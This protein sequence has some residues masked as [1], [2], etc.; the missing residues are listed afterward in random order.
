MINFRTAHDIG[1]L[2]CLSLAEE[3]E[4]VVSALAVEDG[5]DAVVA[6][7]ADAQSV[8]QQLDRVDI[9][10]KVI[11]EF[12]FGLKPSVIDAGFS[13]YSCI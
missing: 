8:G 11:D 7:R 13:M 10:G 1:L 6:A 2:A 5:T 9:V 12:L 3:E 4:L